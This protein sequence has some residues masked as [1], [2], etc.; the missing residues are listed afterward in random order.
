M[1]G[2]VIS[3]PASQSVFGKGGCC[4]RARKGKHPALIRA[5]KERGGLL[6]SEIRGL[7][8]KKKTKR[9]VK[10]ERSNPK[11]QEKTERMAAENDDG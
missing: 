6:T 11:A 5:E 3:N 1:K 8:K 7:K 9:G 4:S 10:R 2:D